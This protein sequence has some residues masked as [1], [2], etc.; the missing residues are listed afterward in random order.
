MPRSAIIFLLL[1]QCSLLCQENVFNGSIK[2]RLIDSESKFPLISAN[3]VIK[4]TQTGTSSDENGQFEIPNL[5]PGSYSLLLSYIGYQ[6][7]VKTD[8]IVRPGRIT[9]VE[10]ELKPVSLNMSDVVVKS[11]YFTQI[12]EQPLSTVS[13][14]AEEVRR[15]P[16]TAGDVSRIV[17]SL[18]SL[19]KVND[20]RNS[21][22]VRGGSPIENA[23]YLDN[24]EIPNINHYAVQGSSDGPIGLINIDFIKD[25]NFYSGGF[26]SSYGDK[27]SSIM[28]LSF[29]EGNRDEFDVQFDM[30]IQALGISAEGPIGK[31]KGSWLF[32]ARRSYFDIL[33]KLV[34][35]KGPKPAY[36][37][38]QG[39]LVYNLSEKMKMSMLNILAVD[40]S[41]QSR[42]EA[43]DFE[44]NNFGGLDNI[45]QTGGINLQ[46]LWSRNA[47]S[48]I[49]LA[50]T[51][52]YYKNAVLETRTGN[53]LLDNT[54][55]EQ[56]IKIRNNNHLTI[57]ASHKI[58]LGLEGKYIFNR[59]RTHYFQYKDRLGA[60]VPGLLVD[61]DF[62]SLKAG[63]YINYSWIVSDNISVHPGIRFDYFHYNKNFTISPRASIKYNLNN[64]S[65]ISATAGMYYQNLPLVFLG[66]KPEYK[67]L[68]IPLSYHYILGFNHLVTENT[69]LTIEVYDKEYMNFPM[70]PSQPYLF[71]VDHIFTDTYFSNYDGI[72]DAGKARSYGLEFIIQKK[73]ADKIYGMVSASYFNAKYRDLN[74]EWNNRIFDNRFTF[75]AEVGYKPNAKWDFSLRWMF[76]GGAPFTPFDETAS[77]AAFRGIYDHN[78]INKSRL[79]DYHSLNVRVDRRFLFNG[80]NLVLYLTIWNTYGRQNVIMYIWDEIKNQVKAEKS[81]STLPVF[82]LEYEL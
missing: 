24:I 41:Y 2:G 15:S 6:Q 73:L 11:N 9:F 13:F 55:T 21:L 31:G 33:F 30:S 61:D 78:Y 59:Y 70:S 54:S 5:T 8:I 69:K 37:D 52:M 46:Y 10:A 19:A 82:G 47:F 62:N 32:S 68:K 36:S 18:P 16:G 3:I 74:G 14:S 80:S 38:Y 81:W 66:Q 65:S 1:L 64:I 48:N 22:I 23:F 28:E 43:Y 58:E 60:L 45:N 34:D 35:I 51:Y 79:P 77:V 12:E 75:S 40:Y 50:H 72:V 27:L 49:S 25:V 63:G 4:G 76:A 44:S 56:E 20:T 57:T 26:S 17:M 53:N 42:E 67:E 39:K 71:I 7:F 29:R